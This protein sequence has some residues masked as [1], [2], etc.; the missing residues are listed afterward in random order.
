MGIAKF[1]AIDPYA[2]SATE[3]ELEDYLSRIHGVMDWTIHHN[4]EVTLEYDNNLI[5]DRLIEDALAGIGFKLKHLADKPKA[6]ESEIEK[7]LK[8]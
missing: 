7:A 3:A 5:N 8:Q 6:S 4:G 1:V 2:P